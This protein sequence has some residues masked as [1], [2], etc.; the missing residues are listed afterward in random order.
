[1]KVF[2]YD[3]QTKK[4]MHTLKENIIIGNGCFNENRV[5]FTYPSIIQM[6]QNAQ[7][8]IISCAVYNVILYVYLRSIK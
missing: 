5:V 1:M 2:V 7:V 3:V 6:S 4:T 8:Y